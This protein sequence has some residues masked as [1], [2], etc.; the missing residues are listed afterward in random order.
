MDV[1][2][3]L[4]HNVQDYEGEEIGAGRTR[5][6]FS[7]HFY[8][9]GLLIALVILVMEA[10]SVSETKV[11]FDE[12][13]RCNI[14]ED[15]H[16]NICRREKLKYCR[17]EDCLSGKDKKRGSNFHVFECQDGMLLLGVSLVI[18]AWRVLRLRIEKKASRYG[19]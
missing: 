8:A 14:L 11:Y 1:S 18:T 9:R 15:S 2:E 5:K 4:R 10:V 19:G 13:N 6:Y 7:T 17:Q 3:V 12:T 16:I